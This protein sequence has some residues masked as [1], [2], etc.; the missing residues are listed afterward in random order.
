[1][2]TIKNLDLQKER[3]IQIQADVDH[4]VIRVTNQSHNSRYCWFMTDDNGDVSLSG[5]VV[6][7]DITISLENLSQ[8]LYH[9][10]AQGEKI[11][12]QVG[13]AS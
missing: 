1:M 7:K 12:L 8:G 9:F 3:V 11:E 6:E 5:N 2:K 10:R 4:N 13:L